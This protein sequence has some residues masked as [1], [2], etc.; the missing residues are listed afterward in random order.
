M[1][2]N[3]N[4]NNEEEQNSNE[5]DDEN[6]RD[7]E[8]VNS[9]SQSKNF[10][11]SVNFNINLGDISRIIAIIKQYSTEDLKNLLEN[12]RNLQNNNRELFEKTIEEAKDLPLE[13]INLILEYIDK[14]TKEENE[15]VRK[16]QQENN[17]YNE[18]MANK[19]L[20]FLA[21]IGGAILV[22]NYLS[23]DD[24][25]NGNNSSNNK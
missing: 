1:T 24:S 25:D 5:K 8:I 2:D 22:G 4:I 14:N 10:P 23:S 12:S 18:A 19:C 16:V 17:R 20:I 13:K 9:G 6:V 11:N 7:P 21:I 3:E 15:H